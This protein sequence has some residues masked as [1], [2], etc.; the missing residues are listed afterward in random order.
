MIPRPQKT[1]PLVVLALLVPLLAHAEGELSSRR[2][3]AVDRA[4]LAQMEKEELVGVAIGV[5]EDNRVVY[6]KGYGF[7]DRERSVPLDPERTMLRWA[8]LSKPLTAVVAM[9]LVEEGVLGLEDDVR[10]WVPDFPDKGATI[11]VRH[12][13]SHQSGIPQYQKGKVFP[14][15]RDHDTPHPYADVELALDT[16]SESPLLFPPGTKYGYSTHAYILLSA[17]VQ[18]AGGKA[19]YEQVRERVM[20]P[21]GMTNLT[22]DWQ[23]EDIPHRAVGYRWKKKEGV[24]LAP[25]TDVSW[26]LGGGGFL[27][28]VADLARFVEGVMND[29]LVRL[30]TRKKMWTKQRLAKGKVT[31][32]GLGFVIAKDDQGRTKII[33][34]GSQEGAATRMMIYPAE[35]R[36]VVV[37]TA[38]EWAKVTTIG[39]L[40]MDAVRETAPKKGR[41][42]TPKTH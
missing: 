2:A 32:A 6:L 9:Q 39:N 10:R 31:E 20:K 27:S 37:M 4:V 18:R 1:L 23:W 19:F 21:L 7:E 8:S 25:D 14:R 17:V 16:F 26:K 13:L 42:K 3:R 33:H 24:V 5:I 12:L 15:V 11:R 36:A 22:P 28:T 38:C 41:A 30:E 34:N 40:V 29:E 35:K